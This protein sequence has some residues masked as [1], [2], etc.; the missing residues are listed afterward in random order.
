LITRGRT[1]IE[2]S[3]LND[4]GAQ[5]IWEITS[6]HATHKPIGQTREENTPGVRHRKKYREHHRCPTREGLEKVEDPRGGER[7][8]A[9][10]EQRAEL[11]FYKPSGWC[12]GI[13][14]WSWKKRSKG[15]VKRR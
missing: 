1:D 11:K 15:V 6:L 12:E 4:L 7:T 13:V 3:A 14:R 8:A 5:K 10:A 2:Q 9:L